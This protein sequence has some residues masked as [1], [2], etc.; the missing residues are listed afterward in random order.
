MNILYD[1]VI[2]HLQKYGGV[3][4]YFSKLIDALSR[5]KD[6]D[7]HILKTSKLLSG[8]L[9][10][11][12]S[13]LLDAN[14]VFNKYDVYHP[15]YYSNNVKKRRN[16]K[17]VLTVHDMIHELYANRFNSIN[18][19]IEI[20]KQSI[21][22]ADH[23]ICVSYNSKKDLQDIYNIKDDMISVVYEGVS[24]T[25]PNTFLNQGSSISEK[26]YILYVGK[27][28][29][30]KNF[31]VLLKAFCAMNLK[32][33]FNLVCFGGQRFSKEES[34]Q[35]KEMCLEDSVKYS[36]G[37]DTLLRYY[38]NK[39]AFFVYP[40]LYE[41][42]GLPILEAMANDCPVIASKG[43]SIP[44]IAGDAALLFSPENENELCSCMK[45]MLNDVSTRN[46]CMERGKRRV[47]DFSWEKAANETYQVYKKV[48]GK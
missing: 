37:D 21:F 35:F 10:R 34:A 24:L 7:I 40:S 12:G 9:S 27:R 47:K 4:R 33:S 22:N 17:T 8:R 48:V 41:G 25:G 13:I 20:K 5:S 26:P 16:I 15:T 6:I 43:G 46:K 38:Y 11:I 30:Y 45:L 23:I 32:D 2:F 44:E 18:S 28:W 1:N 31:N 3:T 42:F 14:V 29:L 39:A 19:G 36:E